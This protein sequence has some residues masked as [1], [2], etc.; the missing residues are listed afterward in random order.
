MLA[1]PTQDEFEIL[2]RYYE[3]NKNQVAA[4]EINPNLP[5]ITAAILSNDGT[6][7]GSISLYNIVV[8]HTAE[9]GISIFDKKGMWRMVPDTIAFLKKAFELPLEKIYCRI[10]KTNTKAIAAA[11]KGGFFIEKEDE[12]MILTMTHEQFEKRCHVLCSSNQNNPVI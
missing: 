1:I 11:I 4:V 12:P 8:K 5:E 10:R 6:L 9:F 7:V 3:Q 2:T